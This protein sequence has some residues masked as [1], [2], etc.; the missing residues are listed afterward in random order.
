MVQ[1]F[2]QF[3]SRQHPLA[4]NQ[5]GNRQPK[6]GLHPLRRRCKTQSHGRGLS[7]FNTIP[8]T[9]KRAVSRPPGFS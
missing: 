8:A 3:S 2:D 9:V 4:I 1:D 6:V 7:S 5:M